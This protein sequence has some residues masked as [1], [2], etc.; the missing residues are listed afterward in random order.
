M[1][2][3]ASHEAGISA[4]EVIPVRVSRVY[5]YYWKKGVICGQIDTNIVWREVRICKERA[6]AHAERL[7]PRRRSDR[8]DVVRSIALKL[9]NT[10]L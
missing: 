5:S 8:V 1:R 6:R 3:V 4:Y 9:V 2:R 10:T 7:R